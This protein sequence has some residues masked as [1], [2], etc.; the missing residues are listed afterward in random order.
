MSPTHLKTPLSGVQL[1][2][3]LDQLYAQI[4][5]QEQAEVDAAIIYHNILDQLSQH[6]FEPNSSAQ[7][8]NLYQAWLKIS[9]FDNAL[10]VIVQLGPKALMQVP[11][12]EKEEM[13]VSLNF[14]HCEVLLAKPQDEALR[15]ELKQLRLKIEEH[16]K[17]LEN[18][19]AWSAAWSHLKEFAHFSEDYAQ[20]KRII[21]I[22]Y[23]ILHNQTNRVSFRAWDA[24]IH[25]LKLAKVDELLGQKNLVLENAQKAYTSLAEKAPDQDVNQN[26]WFK[27]A[28]PMVSFCPDLMGKVL[29]QIRTLQEP[30][31]PL[32]KLKQY[33]IW[34][35]RI[36]AKAYYAQG[37]LADAIEKA[38]DGR[39][40]TDRDKDDDW[41]AL[42]LDWLIEDNQLA[43]AAELAFESLLFE[44][45]I[46]AQKAFELAQKFVSNTANNSTKETQVFWL[47]CLAIAPYSSPVQ[48]FFEGKDDDQWVTD[49]LAIADQIQPQHIATD[50]VKGKVLVYQ[51][52][53]TK[54]HPIFEQIVLHPQYAGPDE[55][56]QLMQ[57]RVFV[58]GLEKVL[59][60]EL[61]KCD[62]G[63][64]C[65][66]IALSVDDYI[67][68]L[69]E[70]G[71]PKLSEDQA[72]AI[73]HFYYAQGV[74]NFERFF[75]SDT[76]FFKD[77]EIHTYSM[78][79]NNLAIDF[80]NRLNQSRQAIALHEKGIQTSPFAEHYD[81]ILR[82]FNYMSEPESYIQAADNLWNYASSYGY[83]RHR[84][85]NYIPK[86]A[87]ALCA[88]DRDG[89][90]AI[91]IERLD[92]WWTHLDTE[93]QSEM[94]DRYVIA[95]VNS[96]DPLSRT[97]KEDA[98]L[99]F[100][101]IKNQLPDSATSYFWC[102]VADFY[103]ELE[104]FANAKKYYEFVLANFETSDTN[105][106][107]CQTQLQKLNPQAS[108]ANLS[109]GQKAWW[110]FW[111]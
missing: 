88:L 54:A 111:A 50:I 62:C 5:Q 76:G 97:Q 92:E 83:G 15:S 102:N 41:T 29:E 71:Y 42:L 107:Y 30:N 25:Y 49:Y 84:P 77:G 26:D 8:K 101:Q 89:E 98:V 75:E 27:L 11:K 21:E 44:R 90:I 24:A 72:E 47:A 99:R 19:N 34:I 43:K 39:Y 32:S 59:S 36:V 53:I 100:N 45:S 58:Y 61:P 37:R 48:D 52:N 87:E 69:V 17:Q 22:E 78:M 94:R 12:E 55:I 2:S 96:L 23:Q 28:E 73:A 70:D 104:D 80:S 105:C 93:D 110:K 13:Q 51:G 6:T 7:I 57:C 46:S 79:C 56:G 63:A 81:G 85:Y 86:A 40:N 10:D 38:L 103:R 60:M 31:L 9:E 1:E 14:W 64:W 109:N 18:V 20:V 91:W 33:N 67:N 82:C 66:S 3:F 16:L 35:A 106:S 65:Y 108:Q 68:A 4:D 74:A 95:L